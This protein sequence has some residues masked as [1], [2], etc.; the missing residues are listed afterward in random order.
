MQHGG[1][2]IVRAVQVLI[3]RVPRFISA[4]PA[5]DQ[6]FADG[7]ILCTEAVVQRPCERTFTNLQ[8]QVRRPARQG[9]QGVQ[10]QALGVAVVQLAQVQA[11]IR[12]CQS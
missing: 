1:I 10:L 2:E 9:G 5:P 8:T 12:A 3:A 4:I 11:F 7:R 6:Y